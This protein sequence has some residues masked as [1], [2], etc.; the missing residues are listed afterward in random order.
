VISRSRCLLPLTVVVALV[1]AAC[2]PAPGALSYRAFSNHYAFRID[3]DPVPPMAREKARFKVVVRDKDT[4]QPIENGEGILYAEN[5]DGLKTWDTLEPGKELGTYYANLNF[6]I[7]GQWAMGM[8]FRRDSL[9][10]LEQV[11]WMQEV[12]AD[13]S[14]IP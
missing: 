10:A 12:V 11:D 6:L 2:G 5:R 8:R 13:T 3:A 1:A 4:G 14:S 9:H 7:A